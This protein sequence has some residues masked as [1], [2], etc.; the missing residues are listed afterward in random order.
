MWLGV[1]FVATLVPPYLLYSVA[2]LKPT[3][4]KR[5]LTQRQLVV[6]S[7]V[8][9]AICMCVYLFFG[10]SAGINYT[11]LWI[12]IPLFLVGQSLNLLVYNLLG[13]QRAYYGWELGLYSGPMLSGFPWTLGHAQYKGLMISV[14]GTWFCFNP[15]PRLTAATMLWVCMYFYITI[16]ETLPPGR[17]D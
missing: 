6:L 10:F 3:T 13:E 5:F 14:I 7:S 15:V 8:L 17:K 12:G 9:K 2:Y 4:F 16:V 1:L 11:G